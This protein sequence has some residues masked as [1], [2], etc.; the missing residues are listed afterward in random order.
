M[1]TRSRL[2]AASLVA[3]AIV[4]AGY[5][6]VAQATNNP[7]IPPRCTPVVHETTGGVTAV[8]GG[9][10]E[11]IPSGLKLTTTAVA[12]KLGWKRTLDNAVPMALV[13]GMRYTTRKVDDGA[14]NPAALV[15][16]H[17]YLRVPTPTGDVDATLVYEPYY[18]ITGNPPLDTTKTWDVKGGK[19]WTNHT[20]PGLTAEPGGSYAGNRTWL[21]ILT[22][23]PK[24]VVTGYGFGQGTYNAGTISLLLKANDYAALEFHSI[25]PKSVNECHNWRKPKPHPTHPPTTPPTR[26]PTTPPTAPPTH[27]APPTTP[28]ATTPP[29]TVPPGTHPPANGGDSYTQGGLAQT[30][31]ETFKIAGL[32][33]TLILI[34]SLVAGA[35]FYWR[36]RT[37]FTA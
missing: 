34:G 7:H 33:L 20:I 14:T 10:A 2:A 26:P 22:A 5:P 32:G 37:R 16:Y 28:P 4:G 29:A 15:A 8:A 23:N 27:T 18:Q 36:R 3:G 11:L 30:G 35:A 9:K 19:F 6:V 31:D 24:A 25:G 13:T 1:H 17:V 21:E 12:D